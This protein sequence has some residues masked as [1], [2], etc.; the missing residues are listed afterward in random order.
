M[1]ALQDLMFAR[2][3]AAPENGTYWSLG[4]LHTRSQQLNASNQQSGAGPWY[5]RA[6][7]AA[8]SGHG[9]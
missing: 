9:S 6:T 7:Q 5:C 3:L 8:D 4:Y 2:V 1:Q